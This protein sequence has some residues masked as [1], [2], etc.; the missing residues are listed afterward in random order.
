MRY[1]IGITDKN[2]FESLRASAPDEVN[3]WQPSAGRRAAVLEPGAPY[4][5]KLHAPHNYIVGGGFF[6]RY[7]ALPAQVAW[8][9]F[10]TKNGVRN[11][12]ELRKRVEQYRKAPILGDPEVGCNVLNDPFFWSESDWIPAP[13]GWARNIV[14]G[15]SYSTVEGEGS[16]IWS[17]VVERVRAAKPRELNEVPRYGAEYLTH[18][19]L[20]QG[21]FRVLVTDAYQRRCA[22]TGEKTL[23]VLQAAHIQPYA[24]RGPHLVAN[25]MLLRSDLHTL[26]DRGY[27][28]ITD[29]LQVEV[30]SRIR[31]EFENGREYY[32]HQGAPLLF[33]PNAV[34][35]RPSRE[36]LRWHNENRFL[37]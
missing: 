16:R 21:A 36:F 28:T 1:W 15:K 29:Q 2:W 8:D 30:S 20:G 18:A 14:Q 25:G 11:Y 4:L 33:M 24:E 7:R 35:D 37:G 19:R 32:R 5:F 6:V 12:S 3:F 10:G 34:Q 23:P 17:A 13:E 22:I 9:A 26:F 31:A 27:L